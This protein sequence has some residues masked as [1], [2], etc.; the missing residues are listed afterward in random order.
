VY[1]P[2]TLRVD[3]T[4]GSATRYVKEFV[5]IT[6]EDPTQEGKIVAT[7]KLDISQH[8]ARGNSHTS[9]V[10]HME[11]L[12][13]PQWKP[14]AEL[15]LDLI[16]DPDRIAQCID[17]TGTVGHVENPVPGLHN[18]ADFSAVSSSGTVGDADALGDGP[19]EVCVGCG[20]VF[21]LSAIL[22]PSYIEM[23]VVP[24][25][26]LCS[27]TSSSLPLKPTPQRSPR[28]TPSME[29]TQSSLMACGE[30]LAT[31]RTAMRLTMGLEHCIQLTVYA[32]RDFRQDSNRTHSPKKLVK[33][34]VAQLVLRVA[35]YLG[36]QQVSGKICT[37]FSHVS[38]LG[39]SEELWL[40]F[41][42]SCF[43]QQQ[44][45]SVRFQMGFQS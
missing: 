34:R 3:A 45:K 16:T 32:E 44:E 27:L 10:I 30:G 14:Q 22:R 12:E 38:S 11:S 20:Q 4:D 18:S 39:C 2:V 17:T 19:M 37:Q 24:P 8:L 43:P 7:H 13:A 31:L 40:S 6:V 9:T 28:R 23:R 15:D 33:L 42:L 26:T 35:D 1:V 21:G 41:R 25:G 36:A 5:T 29:Q